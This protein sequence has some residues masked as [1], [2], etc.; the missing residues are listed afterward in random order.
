MPHLPTF[1]VAEQ[2]RVDDIVI[3]AVAQAQA[4]QDAKDGIQTQRDRIELD[5][6]INQ[7]YMDNSVENLV[8]VV[9]AEGAALDITFPLKAPHTFVRGDNFP[10]TPGSLGALTST[11]D[12]NDWELRETVGGEVDSVSDSTLSVT[13]STLSLTPGEYDGETISFTSGVESGNSFLIATST[14]DTFVAAD[15]FGLA[16]I[17]DDF[18]VSGTSPI[19]GAEVDAITSD[20]DD[21]IVDTS[22]SLVPGISKTRDIK[23]KFTTGTEAGNSFD[24]ID[25]TSDRIR[26][27]TNEFVNV[28][29]SDD[30]VL[31]G[32]G[33]VVFSP[34]VNFVPTTEPTDSVIFY[35]DRWN[36]FD[37]LINGEFGVKTQIDTLDAARGAIETG[38]DDFIRRTEIFDEDF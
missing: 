1:T 20:V 3:S 9:E 36:D 30:F 18:N 11:E 13:D 38:L 19:V 28:S 12:I 27:A 17:L 10:V 6:D 35:R 33:D 15:T 2:Q 29:A 16:A 21:L 25:N 7:K 37:K 8:E 34:T 22:L 23:I 31:L 32:I 4:L 5:L 14:S 26:G 24:V